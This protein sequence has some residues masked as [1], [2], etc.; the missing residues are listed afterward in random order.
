VNRNAHT[1][2]VRNAEEKKTLRKPRLM[3][4][5]LIRKLEFGW[6]EC[7]VGGGTPPTAHSNQFQLFH[8]S[9]R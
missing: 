5:I 8:D 4:I 7:V 3:G 9:C 6:D 1:I 2:L